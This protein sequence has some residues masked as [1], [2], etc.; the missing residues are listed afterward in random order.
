MNGQD[1]Q[2]QGV[3]LIENTPEE[4]RDA[5]IEMLERIEGTWRSQEN[6]DSLQS[7]FWELFPNDALD[8]YSGNR[9]HGEI[10]ARY[11]AAFLR[12]NPE[13]LQ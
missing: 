8:A 6:D 5:A 7:Q 1:F 11:G 4:I 3:E 12:D 13:W 10:R 9:L 2:L